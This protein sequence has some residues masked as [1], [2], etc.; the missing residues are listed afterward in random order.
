MVKK[1]KNIKND[2]KGENRT[3]IKKDKKRGKECKIKSEI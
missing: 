2:G 3:E 1:Q